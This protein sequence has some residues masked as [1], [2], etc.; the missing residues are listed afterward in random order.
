[1]SEYTTRWRRFLCR[2]GLH[3]HPKNRMGKT[4]VEC[5]RMRCNHVRI[6]KERQK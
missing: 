6:H 4:R 3:K 1:M 2:V 5:A